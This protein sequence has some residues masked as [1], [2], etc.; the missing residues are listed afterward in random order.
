MQWTRGL[1]LTMAMAAGAQGANAAV[2]VTRADFGK[3]PDGRSAEVYTIKDADLAVHI[4][5]YGAR[6]V[7]LDAKDRDGKTA[8][9]VLGYNSVQGYVAEGTAKTYFGAI[10]GR[11]GNRIRGGKFVIDGHA[12][13]VPQNDHGN[14]LHGGPHGFDEKLWT[15]KEIPGGVEFT[16]VSPDG[17]MGFPGTLTAHVRYTLVGAALHI[18]YSA[19][20][21]KPTVLNLTNHSYFNLS[22]AGSGT[23][24]GEELMINADKYTP[25][26]KTLI[27][28]GGPQPVAGTPFDFR[29]MTAIGQ[30]IHDNNEQLKIA[31]G[32][33]H[34]WVLNGANGQMKVA[35]KL[36]DPKSGRVLTV[37]TTQPGVQFYSGNFLDGSYKSP[38]GVPY[39]KNTGLCLETQHYPDSPNQPEFPSTLLKPGETMHSETIFA[40][41]TQK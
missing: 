24:L 5:T 4:T 30:R 20:T 14:A 6:I 23:I 17:D 15:A 7:A 26:D 3:L 38:A 1:V 36:Y 40:F 21:T 16:L 10:V 12:Y 8:D 25:V 37:S 28:T 19:T 11:Y 13:Q 9:V 18:N 29:R 31:G 41:S 27:P 22:G 34:N 39:A 35:A 2:T 32:Y 33:D